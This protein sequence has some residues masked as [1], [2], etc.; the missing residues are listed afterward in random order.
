M[1]ANF[2]IKKLKKESFMNKL[3]YLLILTVILSS[4]VA[5]KITT[6]DFFVPPKNAVELIKRVNSKNSYPQW[7]S[8]TGKAQIVQK[9][10]DITLSVNIK[11]RKDSIIWLSAS[12]PFGIEIIRAQL[13]PD[14]IY[15]VNR[16]TKTYLVKP[17][18]QL[19]EFIKSELSFYDL[20]DII[21]AN[22]KIL[23]KDYKLELRATDF[24]LAAD[25]SSY[26]VT[27]NYRIQNA[28]FVDYKMNLEFSLEDY[29]ET[30]NFPRKFALKVEAEESFEATINYSKV[31]FNKPQKI[32]FEIPDSYDEI[33]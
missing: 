19:K 24:Y 8:L 17:A 6:T 20:Q 15:F 23:K 28:K 1:L 16:I 30:D 21:T 31:E 13:T 29:Q 25:S 5:K 33:K 7:L 10:Q 3:S 12:G 4:C 9:D 2:L 22:P 32:V 14:S 18:S 26:S 11:N 27:S